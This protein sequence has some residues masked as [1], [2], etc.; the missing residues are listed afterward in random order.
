MVFRSNISGLPHLDRL[1]G[2]FFLLGMIIM[3][4]RNKKK[5][6]LFGIIPTFILLLPS[7]MVLNQPQEVPS[8]S[9]SIGITPFVY[10]FTAAGLFWI[11]SI[12]RKRVGK[13]L[14]IITV[15]IFF[16]CISYSN[17]F[18]YFFLWV[19]GLP[20]HNI[21]FGRLIADEI[22][23]L[24]PQTKV[25]LTSCCWG[26]WGQPEPEGIF[27]ALPE[28]TRSRIIYNSQLQCKDI[29]KNVSNLIVFNPKD[30]QKITMFEKCFQEKT[31][32]YKKNGETV[33]AFLSPIPKK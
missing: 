1:S 24:P 12:L 28:H 19:Y 23:K 16:V 18:N 17:L 3:L 15:T 26:D 29:D 30:A 32:I 14:S 22:S 21:P 20:N 2:L 31:E 9:R 11:F 8:A 25:Y 27:Y 33:A 10:L 4:K 5:T 6:F 7:V 13:F